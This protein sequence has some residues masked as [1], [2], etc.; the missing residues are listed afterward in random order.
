MLYCHKHSTQSLAF[1]IGN[2]PLMYGCAGGHDEVVKI[3]LANGANVEDHNENGHTPL[4]EAA[5]A[6]HVGVAKVPYAYIYAITVSLLF[7]I[8]LMFKIKLKFNT[9]VLIRRKN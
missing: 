9:Y 7:K 1:L 6:G 4:M 8:Y 3:L 2:T 5:S